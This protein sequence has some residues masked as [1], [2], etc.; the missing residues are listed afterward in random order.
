MSNKKLNNKAKIN[1]VKEYRGVVK[2]MNELWEKEQT[3]NVELMNEFYRLHQLI[4][5]NKDGDF[6][7]IETTD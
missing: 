1:L 2:Q 4:E 3:T 5:F 6:L 7:V